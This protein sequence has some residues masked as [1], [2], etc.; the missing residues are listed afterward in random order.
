MFYA[1]NCYRF[2]Y[3]YM[4][5]D[6]SRYWRDIQKD[7]AMQKQPYQRSGAKAIAIDARAELVKVRLLQ[8]VAVVIAAGLAWEL[9]LIFAR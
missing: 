4:K 7:K 2:A 1:T 6:Q 9:H 8:L 5:V 3:N